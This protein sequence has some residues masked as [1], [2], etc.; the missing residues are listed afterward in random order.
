MKPMNLLRAGSIFV[1]I[2]IA[3]ACTPNWKM[4]EPAIKN[5]QVIVRGDVI[6]AEKSTDNYHVQRFKINEVIKNNTSHHVYIG[7]IIEV[8]RAKNQLP[9]PDKTCTVFLVRHGKTWLV[10]LKSKELTREVL[11]N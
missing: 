7:Q 6:S 1:T 3:S 11:F 9:V 5:A 10:N 4:Y 8:S 2:L